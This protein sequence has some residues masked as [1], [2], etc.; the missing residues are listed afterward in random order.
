MP[1]SLHF[2]ESIPLFE[3]VNIFPE[4]YIH[5]FLELIVFYAYN[6]PEVTGLS[7]RTRA[8]RGGLETPI[9]SAMFAA[10]QVTFQLSFDSTFCI[11]ILTSCYEMAS[12]DLLS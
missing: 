9:G 4:L 11:F 6:A 3:G 7:C 10:W 12:L 8:P 1:E 2:V 5:P